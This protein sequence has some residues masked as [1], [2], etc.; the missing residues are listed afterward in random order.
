MNIDY[1]LFTEQT[2]QVENDRTTKFM[3]K[4]VWF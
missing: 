3:Y 2:Q 1:G 4:L